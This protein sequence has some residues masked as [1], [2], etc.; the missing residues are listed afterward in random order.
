MKYE[1][2]PGSASVGSNPGVRNIATEGDGAVDAR[3]RPSAC[4]YRRGPA[5]LG[6][7]ATRADPH[8][9]A[10]YRKEK[11]QLFE[12]DAFGPYAFAEAAFAGGFQQA[13]RK[14][15]EW[16]T[17]WDAFGVRV[18]SNFGVQLVTTT[19]RY[20]MAEV[21]HQDVAYYRCE[22]KGILSRAG[23]AWFPP[24]WGATAKTVIMNFL[25]VW[26]HRTLAPGGARLVS[27]PLRYEGRIPDGQLQS[28]AKRW[29][30]WLLN[31]LRS[32][33]HVVQPP[34]PFQ[35]AGRDS[36][37]AKSVSAISHS[38]NN[39]YLNRGNDRP[40]ARVVRGSKDLRSRKRSKLR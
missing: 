33:A 23:H 7:S 10:P 38:W 21:L 12:F 9:Y 35:T 4:G 14:P 17:G 36:S 37:R 6:G 2:V 8:L 18:A 19:A 22:C 34:A 24:L 3:W 29:K 30:T 39:F 16:G 11:L 28:W 1:A 13:T 5:G 32:A 40:L 31:L 20:G 15:P 27:R 25:L 26:F